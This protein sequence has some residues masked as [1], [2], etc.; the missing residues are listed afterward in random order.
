[1]MPDRIRTAIL[2]LLFGLA[3]LLGACGDGSQVRIAPIALDADSYCSLDGM[4]L[5]DYPGPK[6]Q[7]HYVQGEPELFCDTVEMF[8]VYLHLASQRP[9]RAIYV[10]DMARNDWQQPK[11]AWIEARSA[12]YVAGSRQHGSMGPTFASFASKAEAAAFAAREGG[13]VVTFEQVTPD[14][15]RLDGGVLKD[16]GM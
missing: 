9:I 5:L 11:D 12:Y 6:A 4:A 3:G 16:R 14:Q 15:V 1:M 13:K 10:Q 2:P 7:I 8:S